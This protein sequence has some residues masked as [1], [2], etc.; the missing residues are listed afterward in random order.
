MSWEMREELDQE[1]NCTVHPTEIYTKTEAKLELSYIGAT[2]HKGG[3][4]IP[5]SY[6]REH[7]GRREPEELTGGGCSRGQ[8]QV[9]LTLFRWEIGYERN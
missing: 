3:A 2:P 6:H 9:L 4:Q 1:S 7:R 5:H 8:N